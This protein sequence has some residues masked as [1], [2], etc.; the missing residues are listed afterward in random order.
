MDIMAAMKLPELLAPA[1]GPEAACAAFENG[2]DAVYLGMRSLS[3]R[4]DAVNFSP[5]ELAG[6]VAYA[7]SLSPRR[8]VY[9]TVNTLL[10]DADLHDALDTLSDVAAAGSDGAI[11]QDPAVARIARRFFPSLPLHASTQMAIH[12]AAGAIAARELG[13]SRV[14]LARELSIDDIA[15]IVRESGVEIETFVH[16]ALCYSYSGLCLFSSHS[17]G[18]S[19][20]RGRCAYCCRE[21]FSRIC[22]DGDCDG[23]CDDAPHPYF[24]MRDLS[25]LSRIPRLVAA[26]VASLKIEGR[27]K[28]PLYVAAVTDLYRRKLDGRLTPEEERERVSDLQTIFSRPVTALHAD[29]R[30]PSSAVIDA[31]AVGHRG[32]QIGV[33]EYV[34]RERGEAWLRFRSSRALERHDGMQIVVPGEQRP[35]GFALLRLR[36]ADQRT[37]RGASLP[38]FD[39]GRDKFEMGGWTSVSAVSLPAARTE[40]RPPRYGEI[41]HD[42]G[43]GGR[44][45]VSAVRDRIETPPGALVEV[46]LPPDAPHIPEGAPIYCASSLAVQRRYKM[47]S[48]PVFDFPPRAIDVAATLSPDGAKL[49]AAAAEAKNGAPLFASAEIA[50]PLDRA[51]QPDATEGAIRKAFERLG[52]TRWTLGSLS[53]NDPDCSFVPASRMN[54]ARRELAEKLD[55]ARDATE[56]ALS[57]K[58]HAEL[59]DT[60]ASLAEKAEAAPGSARTRGER[61]SVKLDAAEA[62]GVFDGAD[63]V[64]LEIGMS[65]WNVARRVAEAWREMRGDAIT[66]IALPPLTRNADW[67]ALENAV[68]EL[69]RA[70]WR[71]WECSDIAGLSLLR[72]LG[73]GMVETL[74]S[75]SPLVALNRIAKAQLRELGFSRVATSA[76]DDLQ[77]I[78]AC[79]G[80]APETDATV[81]QHTPLFIAETPPAI[82]GSAT[83]G[84]VEAD[85]CGIRRTRRSALPIG[86][87]TGMA[88]DGAVEASLWP[89]EGVRFRDKRGRI[90]RTVMHGGFAVTADEQPFCAIDFVGRMREAGIASFR[91]DFRWLPIPRE[92]QVA[93]WNAIRA[94]GRMDFGYH[95]GNLE[96]GLA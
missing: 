1:G 13:F 15:A 24:S 10:R 3:A 28:S 57:A 42:F 34:R 96:R 46:S 14:V 49:A 87:E 59:D 16:G 56:G 36:L 90:L 21:S 92:E 45:S 73:A 6:L 55:A 54:E 53:V 93:I 67:R 30:A 39:I 64:I 69:A 27:M 26:G 4:A 47:G 8:S 25:M 68:A 33:V 74:T 22:G 2:A 7:H 83:D 81:F 19:G 38:R 65:Q 78:V 88:T 41:R 63:E 35:Y 60:I 52:G 40:P 32:A 48:V 80:V 18:R 79:A 77:N 17:T 50:G 9:V 72:G 85:G 31:T 82:G 11:I 61:W 95:A 44:T 29:G 20:N 84:A 76:E 94:R 75:D 5:S 91:C 66:R 71:H 62:P 37:R 86:F 23:D 12:N 51:R 89:E 70:G 43:P 58:R